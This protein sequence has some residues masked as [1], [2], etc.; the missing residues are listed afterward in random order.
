MDC[1]Y[2]SKKLD[3]T[4]NN[5]SWQPPWLKSRAGEQNAGHGFVK[6]EHMVHYKGRGAGLIQREQ[7]RDS[8]L[9][10]VTFFAICPLKR[11]AVASFSLVQQVRSPLAPQL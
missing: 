5:L 3:C 10:T 6:D 4:F 2:E 8:A 7:K 9:P 11:V 1:R